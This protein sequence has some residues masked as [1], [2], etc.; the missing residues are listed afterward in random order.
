MANEYIT[1]Q[2]M[3]SDALNLSPYEVSNV[4]DAA[5]V[6]AALPTQQAS[7]GDFHRYAAYTEAPVVAF[8]DE[9]AGRDFTHSTDEII[10]LALQILDWSFA[11]DKAVADRWRQGGAP[12]WLAR[13]GMRMLQS[14]MF[15]WEQSMFYG[16]GTG[17]APGAF[18]GLVDLLDDLSDNMV[19][20]AG[21]SGADAQAS[22]YLLRA[23]PAEICSIYKG[24][25]FAMGETVVQNMLD[26]SGKNYP[27]YYTPACS[28]VAC[29]QGGAYSAA[30]IANIEPGVAELT[31]DLIY[32]ALSLFPAGM[33]PN[34]LVMN[35]AAQE[36]L[37]GTRTATNVT[38]A[39][40][41]IVDAVSG[42]RVITT[43]AL[44]S[45]EAV[46]A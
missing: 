32:E 34:M 20:G 37:R 43:D 33:G 13:E 7:D 23:N 30:R 28:W 39:P 22:A 38:G 19:I 21:G 44:L 31:D 8:R 29:Q 11:A 10:N 25:S 14:A 3:V 17:G 45:T 41:P 18:T 27:A 12:N 36:S 46:V 6:L 42:V 40:A 4:R 2:D 35:R 24:N 1:T 9:N 26:G 5:P 15:T 16:P